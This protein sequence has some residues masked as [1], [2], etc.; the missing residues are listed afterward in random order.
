MPVAQLRTQRARIKSIADEID[1][2]PTERLIQ[3]LCEEAEAGAR[4]DRRCA[5]GFLA[6]LKV[7]ADLLSEGAAATT[8][9][10]SAAVSVLNTIV[11]VRLMQDLD[12]G[13]FDAQPG[14]VSLV[15]GDEPFAWR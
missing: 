7:G 14:D 2:F 4:C 3:R 8:V 1:R 9:Q 15:E 5:A 12:R 10:L 6:V 11:A 13:A